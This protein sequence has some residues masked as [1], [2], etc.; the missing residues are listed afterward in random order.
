MA[1]PVDMIMPMLGEMREEMRQ[2][3]ARV[4]TRFDGLDAR[5]SAV[6]RI[7]KAQREALEAESILGRLRGA[8]GGGAPVADRA[9]GGGAGAPGSELKQNQ[10]AQSGTAGQGDER[11]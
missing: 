10:A 7:V 8:R 6:E 9:E 11:R 3:F 2:G 4:D 5:L 1:E